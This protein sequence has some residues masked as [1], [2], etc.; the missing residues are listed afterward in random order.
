MASPP[1]A[2]KTRTALYG[3]RTIPLDLSSCTR[4]D[5]RLDPRNQHIQQ[6]YSRSSAYTVSPIR[7]TELDTTRREQPLDSLFSLTSL[8]AA[9]VNNNYTSPLRIHLYESRCD[10]CDRRTN[11]RGGCRRARHCA[12]SYA[13]NFRDAAQPPS[14]ISR[15]LARGV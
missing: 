8:C 15:R 2:C 1:R 9:R 12:M 4:L 7:E 14:S 5:N 11:Q 6:R 3:G 10:H 13:A